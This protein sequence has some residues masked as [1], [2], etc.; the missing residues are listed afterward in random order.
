M[1]LSKA[2]AD[3][4]VIEHLEKAR[5]GIAD[6]K[7]FLSKFDQRIKERIKEAPGAGFSVNWCYN[8]VSATLRVCDEIA[9]GNGAAEAQRKR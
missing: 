9:Q 8:L 2:K 3:Q 7:G 6:L 1:G 4:V 5:E